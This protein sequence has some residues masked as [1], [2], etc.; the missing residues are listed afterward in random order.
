MKRD[1]VQIPTT[2]QTIKG[3]EY[4]FFDATAGSYEATYAVDNTAPAI[5]NVAASAPGDGTATSPGTRT[6]H[7]TRVSTT[8]PART[9]STQHQSSPGLVTSHS[10]QLT[11]LAPNTT[12]YY[13][14]TSTDA[15]TNSATDPDPPAAPRSFT[16]PSASFTDTTVSD[17]GAGT[18]DANTYISEIEQRRGHPEAG[19]GPGVLGRT[20]AAGRLGEPTWESLGGG[21][22]GSATVS[23]GALHVDGAFAGT[24]A[25]FGPGHSLEFEATFGAASFQHVAFTDNFN[26]AWAMFS[27]RG[28]NNQLFTS[29][30]TGGG[31]TDT[32]IGGQYIGSAHQYRI[33][34]DAGQVQYYV[35]GTL[36]HTDNATFGSNLKRRGQ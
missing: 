27:T 19:R 6:R 26:S 20:R 16:T 11:G 17:F 12:Y 15:A 30:N 1:G 2:T 3:V 8:A 32:P 13:R 35:D 4:A 34:W 5:S 10:V 24:N 7:L 33:E 28:S 29:T 31:A 18:P 9:R 25:T 23:G 14:V 22:G 36:V 21:A